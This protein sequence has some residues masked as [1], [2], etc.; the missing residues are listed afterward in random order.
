M[1]VYAGEPCLHIRMGEMQEFR[2]R[3]KRS[4][5]YTYSRD[6]PHFQY[7]TGSPDLTRTVRS[8]S[9]YLTAY[10]CC[11]DRAWLTTRQLLS[12]NKTSREDSESDLAS[13]GRKPCTGSQRPRCDCMLLNE[14]IVRRCFLIKGVS[15][16]LVRT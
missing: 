2:R 16:S 10:G 13:K 3:R 8:M 7:R 1:I 9:G 4:A 14:I 5:R 15:P 12:S 6:A 11:A